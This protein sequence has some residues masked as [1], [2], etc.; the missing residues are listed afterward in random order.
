MGMQR[1]LPGHP[2]E[3]PMSFEDL[4][5]LRA[6][7]YI[8]DSTLDQRD[9]FGPDIQHDNI[10]RF[11]DSYSL[12]FDDFFYAEF[13]S[14]R[15]TSK[16]S[17]FAQFIEDARLDLYDVLLVDHTSRFGRNQEECIKYKA[18]L[19][20][21]GKVVVF[22]SQGIISGSD[23]DFLNERINETLDEVYSRNL[24]RYISS[25]LFVPRFQNYKTKSKSRFEP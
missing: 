6:R 24:S 19:R 4:I 7:G 5:G 21:L 12:I 3:P 15:S 17:V 25:G 18:I 1:S 22:V 11:A 9:G 2:N 23:R 8:R 13:V 20:E 14:G 10:Q 16:R